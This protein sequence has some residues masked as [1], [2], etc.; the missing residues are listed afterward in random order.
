MPVVIKRN[1]GPLAQTTLWTRE[2]WRSVGDLIVERIKLRTLA[3]RAADGSPFAPYSPAYAALKTREVG[4]TRVD[5]AVSGEM[6][7]N[8]QPIEWTDRSVTVG[9]VR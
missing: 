8:M 1:F 3:G 6:L 5:L 2:D 9:W 7:N 4:T